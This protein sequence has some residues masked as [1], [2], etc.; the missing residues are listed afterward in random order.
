MEYITLAEAKSYITFLDETDTS[1]D[2]KLNPIVAGVNSK[3]AKGTNESIRDDELHLLACEW[4]E[5]KFSSIPGVDKLKEDDVT[6]E[7]NLNGKGIPVEFANI[8]AS[9]IEPEPEPD[10][11]EMTVTLI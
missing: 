2:G 7:Y 11:N 9:Y 8:M 4:V 6:K 5:W 10:D 1:F 3:I